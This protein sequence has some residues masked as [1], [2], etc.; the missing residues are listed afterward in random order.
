[1]VIAGVGLGRGAEVEE[2]IVWIYGD[3]K[4]AD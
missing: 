3:G 1:M 2:G 4:K